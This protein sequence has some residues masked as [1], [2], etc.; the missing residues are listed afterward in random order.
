MIA[1]LATTATLSLG[2]QGEGLDFVVYLNQT[3]PHSQ[4]VHVYVYVPT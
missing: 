2:Q 4:H 1:K 3:P